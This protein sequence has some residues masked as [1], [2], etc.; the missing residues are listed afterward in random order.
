[1]QQAA[2]DFVGEDRNVRIDHANRQIVLSDIFKWF[3]N[4]FINDLRNRGL[5]SERGLIAYIAS[6][7]P[8]P[9]RLEIERSAEY[10]IVFHEYDWSIN[11]AD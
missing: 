2:I 7:A 6:I 3:K 1:M 5:P 11:A 4:D 9:L 10:K 8:E